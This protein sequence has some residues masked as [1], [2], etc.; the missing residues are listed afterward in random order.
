MVEVK[1]KSGDWHFTVVEAKLTRNVENFGKMDPYT[2]V[3]V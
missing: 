2:I 1:T 3:K